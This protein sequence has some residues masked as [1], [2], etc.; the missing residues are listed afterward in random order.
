LT[1]TFIDSVR[2]SAREASNAPPEAIGTMI[3]D[4]A[5]ACF[6][7]LAIVG[8]AVTTGCLLAHQLQAGGLWAPS[9]LAP[10]IGRL[11]R[12]G[13]GGDAE[14]RFTARL[15]EGIAQFLASAVRAAVLV[16]A[17]G[18]AF[19]ANGGLAPLAG[20]PD[21]RTLLSVSAA[22]IVAPLAALA[23]VALVIGL[24]DY[25]LKR[26]KFD[27]ML[28]TTPDEQRAEQKA[29]DGDPAVRSRRAQ[30][31]RSWLRD[32]G[33][34]LAGTA[35]VVTGKAGLTVLLAGSPPP[36]RVTVRTI[37]RGIAAS[38]LRHGAE[39]AGVPLVPHAELADWFASSRA[40]RRPLPPRLA[41]ELMAHWPHLPR[42]AR[43]NAA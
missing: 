15:G 31:A 32:P 5:L 30:L 33:E 13:R 14:G 39:R 38:S 34:M 20:R 35:M 41:A 28:Q 6:T 42:G 22:R 2:R 11:W 10:D 16:G 21:M 43:I 27:R 12:P 1:T 18:V 40:A 17:A 4:R 37:A 36:G 9:R 3:R 29:I 7:C 8:V 23:A 25:G 24:V 26:L 19:W